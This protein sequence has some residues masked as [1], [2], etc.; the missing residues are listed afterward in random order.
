M[1]MPVVRSVPE[2]ETLS[3]TFDDEDVVVLFFAQRGS[4][5]AWERSVTRLTMN[6]VDLHFRYVP[7]EVAPEHLAPFYRFAST[8]RRVC[9]LNHTTPHKNN[10]PWRSDGHPRWRWFGFCHRVRAR[11]S[12][13]S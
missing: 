12:P 10:E 3:R 4:M 11:Q 5:A 1:S 13:Q 8:D 6:Q 2:L 7:I 9:G